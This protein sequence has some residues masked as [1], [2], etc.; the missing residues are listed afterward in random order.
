M[1]ES[2]TV[3]DLEDMEISTLDEERTLTMTEA[4]VQ[5]ADESSVPATEPNNKTVSRKVED[6]TDTILNDIN[7]VMMKLINLDGLEEFS[8]LQSRS[9][10]LVSKEML[11]DLI[12]ECCKDCSNGQVCGGSLVNDT[13][14]DK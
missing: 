2:A 12:G 1:A 13:R 10:Y 8:S 6:N 7:L 11:L 4:H 5:P 14:V 9:C 3:M